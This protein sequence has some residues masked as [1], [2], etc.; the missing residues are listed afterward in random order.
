MGTLVFLL[1]S[2]LGCAAERP[3]MA[4]PAETVQARLERG[5]YLAENVSLCFACHSEV[6]WESPTA[7][8]V[9]GTKGA[10]GPFP[11]TTL[12]F[13]LNSPNI[14]SD[15]ETG[16]GRWTDEQLARAIRQ[17]IG[18]DGR[19]LFP[20]M[21]YHFYHRLSDDDLASLIAYLRS[22]PPVRN[23]LA[24]TPL[25]DEIQQT[26]QPLP[27]TGPAAP[28][29]V[30]SP[31]KRGEYLVTLALCGDCHTPLDEKMQLMTELTFA[32]GRLM[33]GAWGELVSANIT[34]DASGITHYDEELFLK[35]MHTGNPGGRQLNPIMLWGYYR[36]MRDEDLKAIFAYLQTVKPVKHRVD[37]TETPTYCELC[38]QT[39]G[40]GDRN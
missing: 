40:F 33:K 13:P 29:D 36:N 35:V 2:M 11:E 25:P 22:L 6:D 20:G 31:A 38:R 17:G 4:P 7:P 19:V 8:I 16:A 32:G 30:S 39:H 1:V 24:K 9:P 37:N 21:P 27:I 26:L 18:H 23:E 5:R 3:R 34:P 10:G 12:P 28:P 14:T 15:P